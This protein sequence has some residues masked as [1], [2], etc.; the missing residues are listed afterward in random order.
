MLL[1]ESRAEEG[2][3]GEPRDVEARAFAEPFACIRLADEGREAGA[4]EAQR[5]TGRVLVGIEPDHQHTEY[6]RERAA[7]QR[8]GP[9]GPSA[10]S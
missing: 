9:E 10:S 2:D 8:A 3:V 6:R 1:E 7:G 5:E 4:E